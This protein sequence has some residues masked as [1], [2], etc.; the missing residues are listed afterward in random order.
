MSTATH[1][2]AAAP[3]P[4]W[5]PSQLSLELLDALADPDDPTD[6]ELLAM[7]RPR[8]RADCENGPRPCPWVGCRHNTYLSIMQRTGRIRRARPGLDPTE[9]PAETSCVR[10]STWPNER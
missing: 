2:T 3:P 9:V 10:A 5:Q 7:M 6:A 8:T 1:H 4:L